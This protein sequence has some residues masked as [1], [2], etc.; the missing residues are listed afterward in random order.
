MEEMVWKEPGKA[1]SGKP[2]SPA[3]KS[4]PGV[5]RGE[6]NS[7]PHPRPH[8]G[9]GISQFQGCQ[10]SRR[11]ASAPGPRGSAQPDGTPLTFPSRAARAAVRASSAQASAECN[12]SPCSVLHRNVEGPSPCWAD[13]RAACDPEGPCL[14]SRC[15][16]SPGPKGTK[17]WPAAI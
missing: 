7:M 15:S 16:S 5:A 12:L 11:P 8:R 10:S 6:Q 17:S 2:G 14:L 9:S 13:A 4:S 1:W 3:W